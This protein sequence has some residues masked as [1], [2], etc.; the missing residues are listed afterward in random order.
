MDALMAAFVAA[1]LAEAS[2]R[3]PWLGA[4]L[5]TRFNK[6]GAVILATI[7]AFAAVNTIGAIGG[8]L[9]APHISPNAQNLLFA[10][11]LLNAGVSA[12]WK[13]KAPDRLEGWRLGAFLT[14]LLGI[15]ILAFGE[16]TQFLTAAIAARSPLPALAAV[17]ATLGA[18]V[19][20]IPAILAGEP[21]RAHLPLTPIR[22]VIGAIF[23]I[24]G[25][26]IGLGAL[27]LI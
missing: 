21:A 18:A 27:R 11:A 2:D 19:I 6:P 7:L 26:W 1:V 9:I 17:G 4:I 8:A 13:L 10:L 16:R 15:F 12:L 5:G 24:A 23:V 22:I 14:S 3:T 25:L 20:N